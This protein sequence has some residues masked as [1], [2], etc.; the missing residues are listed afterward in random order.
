MDAKAKFGDDATSCTV[1][2]APRPEFISPVHKHEVTIVFLKSSKLLLGVQ[3]MSTYMSIETIQLAAALIMS[4]STLQQV[5]MQDFC[6]NPWFDKPQTP[7]V[8]VC[9]HALLQVSCHERFTE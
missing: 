2:D 5:I 8:A 7:L 4:K 9:Q 3:M 1:V 6:F